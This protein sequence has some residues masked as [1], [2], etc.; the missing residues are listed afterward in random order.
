MLIADGNCATGSCPLTSI[1]GLHRA[2]FSIQVQGRGNRNKPLL[3]LVGEAPGPDEDANGRPFIGKAGKLLTRVL[4]EA[5]IPEEDIWITNAVR[6][7]PSDGMGGFRKPTFEELM[8]CSLHLHREILEVDPVLVVALGATAGWALTGFEGVEARRNQLQLVNLDGSDR[9]YPLLVTYHPSACARKPTNEP[10]LLEDLKGAWQ[11]ARN[12]VGADRVTIERVRVD[13]P[14]CKAEHTRDAHQ[15]VEWISKADGQYFA[16]DCEAGEEL[17]GAVFNPF[18][19]D[20][21]LLGIGCSWDP[22]F[23]FYWSYQKRM[24][25]R[26]DPPSAEDTQMVAGALRDIYRRLPSTMHNGKYDMQV[27]WRH[28][29]IVPFKLASD[30]CIEDY[31]ICHP[32]HWHKLESVANRLLGWPMFKSKFYEELKLIGHKNTFDAAPLSRVAEIC[33]WDASA[34]VGIAIECQKKIEEMSLQWPKDLLMWAIEHFS[35]TEAFGTAIDAELNQKLLDYYEGYMTSAATR[36]MTFG[37]VRKWEQQLQ[38]RFKPGSDDDLR[39]L[40]FDHM[41]LPSTSTSKKTGKPQVGEDALED[42]QEKLTEQGKANDDLNQ[43]LVD[44]VLYRRCRKFRGT[45]VES[46]TTSS[47]EGTTLDFPDPILIFR[48]QYNMIRQKNAR[49]STA[50]PSIHTMPRKS[51]VRRQLITHWWQRGGLLLGADY[52]QAELRLLASEC[53]DPVFRDMILSGDAHAALARIAYNIPEGH[54]VPDLQRQHGKSTNFAIVYGM[55]GG[56]LARKVGRKKEWAD[57]FLEDFFGKAPLLKQWIDDRHAEVREYGGV[58]LPGGRI[59]WLPEIRSDNK[60]QQDHALRAGQNAPIQAGASDMT[61]VAY[62]L[63]RE[64]MR[65]FRDLKSEMFRF[66][67]DDVAV[68]VFPGE[69]HHLLPLFKDVM[70]RQV[71]EA[72]DWVNI[73]LAADFKLEA[74]WEGSVD[75]TEIISTDPMILEVKGPQIWLKEVL[76]QLKKCVTLGYYSKLDWEVLETKPP[77]EEEPLPIQVAVKYGPQPKSPTVKARI[78]VS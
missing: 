41:L 40:L 74:R 29:G 64:E 37:P 67:H 76:G 34:T 66:L 13:S 5:E 38:A 42:L 57:A 11:H 56:G 69:L 72:L 71:E 1:C 18:H 70:E 61:L 14:P 63:M 25:D 30:P 60:G 15:F 32:F 27:L 68:D 35:I 7:L 47:V 77:K 43:F 53:G 73:P 39:S 46:V 51:A 10:K 26:H 22:S 12:L 52:A 45:Y 48:P 16:T 49:F 21:Y 28:L 24:V 20:H 75:I 78:E 23:G 58:R 50:D 17:E 6:C 19:P 2:A 4:Y 8:A 44:N 65:R 54:P 9:P 31:L 3:A 62:L 55:D 33:V 36:M 59:R